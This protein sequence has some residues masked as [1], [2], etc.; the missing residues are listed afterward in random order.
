MI[1]Q[2]KP[3]KVKKVSRSNST[4]GSKKKTEKFIQVTS[5]SEEMEVEAIL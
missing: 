1:K 2:K 5:A 4:F 3:L